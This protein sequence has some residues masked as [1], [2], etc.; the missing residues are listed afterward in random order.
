MTNDIAILLHEAPGGAQCGAL[1]SKEVG[2][3]QIVDHQ[4]CGT[5]KR[6]ARYGCSC[7]SLFYDALYNL[8]D[9]LP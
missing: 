1:I 9:K 5:I 4:G 7:H 2:A 3:V 6:S 8:F